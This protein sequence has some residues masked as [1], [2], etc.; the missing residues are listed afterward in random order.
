M[1][2]SNDFRTGVTIV[3]DGNL[4]TVVDFQHVKPG[5]G[6][7]FVRTRLKNVLRGNVLEKT[8][9]AGEMLERAI[10][11]TRDM[12]YLYGSGD[13]FHFMDQSNYE[14]IALTH[15]VLGENTDLLKEGMGITVQFH[16]G[17]VIAGALP[18][19]IEL[20]VEETDP[21]FR[22]DTAT[23]VTK[24]AKL[25][26]GAMIQVPLFINPGDKIRIDTRDRKY[27]ARVQ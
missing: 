6:S 9:R 17:R 10:I 20:R 26:T 21:G 12:Q 8:F 24:P 5:K 16:D 27:I 1:I 7:A 15:D 11:E 19:H 18:N 13:E 2:S 4:W 23:N 14:Q 3:V 25:E 22:G